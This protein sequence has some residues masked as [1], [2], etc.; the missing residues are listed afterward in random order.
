MYHCV[1]SPFFSPEISW[2][3]FLPR[4]PHRVWGDRRCNRWHVMAVLCTQRCE[5]CTGNKKGK[6]S[7]RRWHDLEATVQLHC[8]WG[9]LHGW[10]T[11]TRHLWDGSSWNLRPSLSESQ[12]A[13]MRCV[14]VHWVDLGHAGRQVAEEVSPHL[15]VHTFTRGQETGD[16][17]NTLTEAGSVFTQDGWICVHSSCR[18]KYKY[19]K[20]Q[21]G[22][23]R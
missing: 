4:S 6:L 17:S 16:L 14:E 22:L 20:I 18:E 10:A 23:M 1:I 8:F 13:W 5:S 3:E 9:G 21:I 7:V 15:C 2:G 19:I 12:R 11:F